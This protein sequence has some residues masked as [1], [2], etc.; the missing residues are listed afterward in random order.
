V[1]KK[2]FP[3]GLREPVAQLLYVPTGKPGTP[4]SAAGMGLGSVSV[5][6]WQPAASNMRRPI[7]MAVIT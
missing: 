1:F 7:F 2:L 6:D 3:D 5:R 4:R